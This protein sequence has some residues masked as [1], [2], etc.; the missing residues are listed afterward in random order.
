MV[1]YNGGKWKCLDYLSFPLS[2]DTKCNAP[3]MKCRS[4][5]RKNYGNFSSFGKGG[6]VSSANGGQYIELRKL[7]RPSLCAKEEKPTV[8]TSQTPTSLIQTRLLSEALSVHLLDFFSFYNDL[9]IVKA[10]EERNSLNTDGPYLL[11]GLAF[12]PTREKTYL[13]H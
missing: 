13:M 3:V 9:K 8:D 7:V 2:G 1:L 4:I 10:S 11:S 6:V 5:L 12:H